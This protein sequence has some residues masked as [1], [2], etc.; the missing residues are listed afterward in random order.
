MPLSLRRL[1]VLALIPL[2]LGLGGCTEAEETWTFDRKGGG[3]YALVLRWNADLWR[4]VRG[5]LGSKVMSRLAADG[6]P[7]R[8]ALWRDGL[9]DLEGVEIV[10]L[11]ERDTDTGMRELRLRARFQKVEQILR[12]DVLAGRTVRIEP[13]SKEGGG[14][15]R[16]T[17]YMEPIARVPILDRIAALVEAVEKAPPAPKGPAADRDP[18][19][20]ERIGIEASAAEMVWRMVRLPLGE[21]SLRTRIVAPGELASVRGRPVGET[22]K[23]ADFTWTFAD[24]RRADADRTVRLRWDMLDFDETRAVDHKGRKDPR[25]GRAPDGSRK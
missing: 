2:F 17:L 5:V 4:R 15:P 23:Q 10:E 18:P 11:E 8:T 7:L 1:A 25:A 20:L 14:T 19:P 13:G 6:F 16:A 22:T 24:L 12:W 9:K 21:V 3:E